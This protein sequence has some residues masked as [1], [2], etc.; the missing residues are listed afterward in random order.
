LETSG[1]TA[2]L[3]TGAFLDLFIGLDP[4]RRRIDNGRRS[5]LPHS[6]PFLLVDPQPDPVGFMNTKQM[7]VLLVAVVAVIVVGTALKI[8]LSADNKNTN[9]LTPP[10]EQLEFPVKTG[11]MHPLDTNRPPEFEY[12]EPGHHDFWFENKMNEPVNIRLTYKNCNRCLTISVGLAPPD[13]K[14]KQKDAASAA[15]LIGVGGLPGGAINP[16]KDANITPVPPNDQAWTELHSEAEKRLESKPF[17]IPAKE[18]GW[19]RVAWKDEDVAHKLL[20][21]KFATDAASGPGQEITLQVPA[22]FVEGVRV[23][24]FSKTIAIEPLR[25]GDRSREVEFLVLSVTRDDF[26]LEADSL[27]KQQAEHPFVTCATPVRLSAEELKEMTNRY[28][29]FVHCGYRV[30]VTV[31]ERLDDGRWNSIGQFRAT[32]GLKTNALASERIE[33][34]VTGTIYGEVTV[35]AGENEDRD[36][37][38]LGT[39]SSQRGEKRSVTVE[40]DAGTELT[41]DRKP[42]FMEVLL[43]KDGEP[44]GGRQSWRLTVIIKPNEV[45]GIFPRTEDER[46]KDTSIYLKTPTRPVRILVSGQADR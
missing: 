29:S 46:Y 34:N 16:T 1:G 44:A 35:I 2:F 15:A 20:T 39:F 25:A 10:V 45:T 14:Q 18:S 11:P 30:P 41:V 7:I 23:D 27:E 38:K 6:Y 8:N 32:F 4:L 31:R 24:P 28:R 36:R 17:Q 5:G 42:D 22:S 9:E 21:A 12:T 33:L 43:K 13:W 3:R 26:T 19:V 40:S 37:I